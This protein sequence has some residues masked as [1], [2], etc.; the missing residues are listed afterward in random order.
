MSDSVENYQE[1]CIYC[2][3]TVTMYYIPYIIKENENSYQV[4]KHELSLRQCSFCK[5]IQPQED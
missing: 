3:K 4:T 5:M 1:D 2:H